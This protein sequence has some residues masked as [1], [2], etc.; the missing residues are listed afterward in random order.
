MLAHKFPTMQAPNSKGNL[1]EA[2]QIPCE[3]ENDVN[4]AGLAEVTGSCKR[5]EQCCLLTI[6]IRDW[7][8][9]LARWSSLHGFSN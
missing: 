3:I 2:F 4:S 8:L 5:I 1:E 7:R 9:P 6:G